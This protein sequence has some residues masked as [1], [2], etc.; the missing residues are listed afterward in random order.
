MARTVSSRL[1]TLGRLASLL[2]A[3]LCFAVAGLLPPAVSP[4]TGPAA[5]TQHVF[6][7]RSW[8]SIG[9]PESAGFDGQRLRAVEEYARTLRAT[10]LMVIAG[11]RVLLQ[12]GDLQELSYLA[13]VRKNVL[14]MLYGNYVA[15][16]AVRLDRTLRDLGM[17]DVG[18]LLPIEQEATVEHLLTARSG[19]YHPASNPGDDTA[20]AP[21]RGSQAPGTYFLYNNW[22]FNAAGHAFEK[23]TG[24][25]IYDARDTDLARPIGMEDF[26][27]SRQR[28][29]GDS[30]RSAYPA[31][32]MWLSTRDMARVGH[33]MLREGRWADQQVIPHDWA[34]KI[35]GVVTPVQQMNPSGYRQGP[36]GFGY[37][38]WVWDGPHSAGP[39][40]G[41]YTGRG[42]YGQYITV[43]PALDLVVAHKTAVAPQREVTWSQYQ[44][45]LNRVIAARALG[46]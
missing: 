22:D 20:H 13:S 8:D 26:D 30:S 46:R 41:A 44:G 27:R 43:L 14:A 18:G 12:L 19:V 40:R 3:A 1:H 29:S 33:L 7:G 21:P 6:P 31:Y 16:G 39:Y 4:Q 35:V 38:W 10:G 34:R 23:M 11:G 5:A 17:S 15:S 37:C 9:S 42:A 2:S 25:D 32:H 45:I 36:F 24:R 28:K